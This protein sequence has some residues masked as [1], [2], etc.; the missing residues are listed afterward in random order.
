M[1]A[2]AKFVALFKLKITK[3]GEDWK[4]VSCHKNGMFIAIGVFPVELL[5]YQVSMVCAANWPRQLYSSLR[6]KRFRGAKS[7]ERGFRRFARAQNG[8]RAN[9]ALSK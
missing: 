2:R 4:R 1:L 5:A 8:A 3:V 6:S 7:E 9:F